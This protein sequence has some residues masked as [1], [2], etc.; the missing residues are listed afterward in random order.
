MPLG[1]RRGATLG[2]VKRHARARGKSR[3]L[4]ALL[5]V[6]LATAAVV[7]AGG[8]ALGAG[9]AGPVEALPSPFVVTAEQVPPA[10][11]VEPD[12]VFTVVAGGDVLPHLPVHTSARAAAG[13]DFSTVLAGTDAWVGGA[14][15]ALCHLEVPLT[16]PGVRP[17]GY[18]LF[19]ADAHLATDL[20]EQGWDGC[21]TASNHSVDQGESG[22]VTTLDALDAAGLGHVGT[23]RSAAEAAAPALYTLERAGRSIVVAHL[24]GTY[25]TNG[26]PVP[27]S[28]PWSVTLLDEDDLVARARA[29]REAG[30]DLVIVSMHSGVEYSTPPTDQQVGLATFLAASGEV[31]LVL[32]HHAHVPQPT[33]LLPGGPDG[34]GMWVAYGLGNYV[35]NQDGD[36]CDA[37]TDS[38]LLVTATITQP[39]GAAARVTGFEWTAITVDR[40]GRHA[41]LA[42]ADVASDG[43]R[44]LS[45]AN[46]TARYDRVR[47]AVGD[48]APERV[49]PP[50]ASGP[51]PTVTSRAAGGVDGTPVA[52]T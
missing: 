18:P 6:G 9:G 31:D 26:M 19:A 15:L 2:A 8:L 36:C 41:V 50:V 33:A 21:S 28:A 25:G 51:P 3:P 40:L 7:V 29:A 23:A 34:Q 49:A 12:A 5:A 43:T 13:Y 16:P 47:A 1:A 35:S 44:T 4:V 37:R 48:A 20:R 32:G 11:L 45:P 14:D 38:G 24:A 39:A 10:P 42:L 17:T 46:L 52:G 27:A 30:A 22:V